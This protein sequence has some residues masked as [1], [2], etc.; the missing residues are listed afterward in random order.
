M[1]RSGGER[2]TSTAWP[3]DSFLPVVQVPICDTGTL[4]LRDLPLPSAGE[5][6]CVRGL[7]LGPPLPQ[8]ERRVNVPQASFRPAVPG[9]ASGVP[10]LQERPG[11]L[12]GPPGVGRGRGRLPVSR[13]KVRLPPLYSYV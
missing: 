11:R 3:S 1:G 4:D 7:T 13:Q 6:F 8:Q 10:H 12:G 2:D 5:L 9:L